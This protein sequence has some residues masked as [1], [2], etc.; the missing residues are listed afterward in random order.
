MAVYAVLRN[1]GVKAIVFNPLGLAVPT[2]DR[3]PYSERVRTSASVTVVSTRNRTHIE[4]V[5]ALSLAG[6]SVLPGHI[7]VLEANVFR[8]SRL[9][10]ATIV[11]AALEQATATGARG[12]ACD[13]DIGEIAN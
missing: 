7:F 3:V 8:P 2:W 11:V 9:H 4:P 1:P 5:T 12:L 6:R 10:S 13:G